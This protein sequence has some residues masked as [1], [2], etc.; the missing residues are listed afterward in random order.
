[1]EGK[2]RG[3]EKWEMESDSVY[4]GMGLM[5]S[6]SDT[7]LVERLKIVIK[8][9]KLFYIADVP[10]NPKPVLF[11]LTKVGNNYFI[12]KNPEHDFPQEIT[13]RLEDGELKATVSNNTKQ[14]EC[15]FTKQEM[16]R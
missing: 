11:E 13:Y 15:R 6:G 9:D 7:V 16:N 4:N 3:L 2:K 14:I 5:L 1:M 12:S 10:E 8:D